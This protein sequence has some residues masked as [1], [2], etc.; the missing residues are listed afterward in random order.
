MPI[1]AS[2]VTV[3]VAA[4]LLSEGGSGDLHTVV[5]RNDSGVTVYVGGSTVSTATGLA[6]ATASSLTLDLANADALYGVVAAATAPV[7]VLRTRQ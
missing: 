1:I 2:I 3:G 7:Q 5:V 6:L 4:T